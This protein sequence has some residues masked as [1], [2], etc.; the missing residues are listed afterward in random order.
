[1]GLE[2][3][4]PRPLWRTAQLAC[5]ENPEALHF[6][7]QHRESG[8]LARKVMSNSQQNPED[9]HKVTQGTPKG[10]HKMAKGTEKAGQREPKGAQRIPKG[11]LSPG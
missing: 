3:Q 9:R 11:N 10:S 5:W 2:L 7:R 6:E 8:T 4:F 1:M